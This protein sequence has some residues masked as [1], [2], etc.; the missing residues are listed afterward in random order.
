MVL[1]IGG[2]LFSD[3]VR[4]PRLQKIT[5]YRFNRLDLI[6]LVEALQTTCWSLLSV[7]FDYCDARTESIPF[8][9]GL[10]RAGRNLLRQANTTPS[11]F[12]PVLLETISRAD[13]ASAVFYFV[14]SLGAS[15]VLGEPRL[16]GR[17]DHPGA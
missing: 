1:S 14:R 2:N 3:F 11:G 13:N 6:E 12:W 8:W 15:G 16:S 7:D 10:N 9:L 4:M 5:D 17:R